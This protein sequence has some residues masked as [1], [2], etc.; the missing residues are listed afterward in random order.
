[1]AT[2]GEAVK[3]RGD[4][5]GI[6]RYRCPFAEAEVGGDSDAGALLEFAQQIEEQRAAR[7]AERQG[8][9][10]IGVDEDQGTI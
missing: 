6:A 4:H 10:F 2:L 5:L 9:R 8:I 1:M 7:G 3:K